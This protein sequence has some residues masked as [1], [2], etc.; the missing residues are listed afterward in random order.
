MEILQTFFFRLPILASFLGGVLAFITPCILPLIPSYMSYI[1]GTSLHNRENYSRPHTLRNALLFVSGF[2]IVFFLFG[3][4][5]INIIDNVLH[6][7]I[8][9]YLSGGLVIL[10]G[11]HFL[12]VLPIKILYH[13]KQ[14]NLK[15]FE[16]NQILKAIAPFI[17]GVGFAAGW[18][19]CTGPIVS[20]IT[21]LASTNQHLAIFAIF[22]FVVGLALPFLLLAIFL[23]AGLSLLRNL[24]KQMR[25]IEILCGI[26]LVFVGILII[27]DEI[28]FL[29]AFIDNQLFS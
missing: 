21:L 15:K 18:T 25:I 14:I 4:A 3:L 27:L 24:K 28:Y 7:P 13:T 8:V 19:P 11:L 6:Y 17:F 12:G 29:V 9:R 2:G 16:Q 23:E 5:M 26:F 20:S 22:A 1:S 10:F